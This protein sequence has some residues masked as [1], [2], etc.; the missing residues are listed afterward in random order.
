MKKINFIWTVMIFIALCAGGCSKVQNGYISDKLIYRRNPQIVSAGV[1]TTSIMPELNGTSQ[2]IH[3]FIAG[4]YDSIGKPTDLL[5]KDV[6]LVVWDQPYVLA[7]DTTIAL[8]N[9]KRKTIKMPI[10]QLNERSGQFTFTQASNLA[11]KG[12]YSF[13]VRMENVAGSQVFKNAMNID[14][15]Q[16]LYSPGRMDI[17]IMDVKNF[18]GGYITSPTATVKRIDRTPT[19]QSPNTISFKIVDKHG[20]PWNPKAGEIVPRGDRPSFPSFDRFAPQV[21]TDSTMTWAYPFAPFPLGT[22]ASTYNAYDVFYRVLMPR[23][24]IDGTV[25][26]TGAPCLPGK[27]NMNVTFGFR[28]IYF[29]DWE[30]TIHI[31]NATRI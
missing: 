31:D 23:V 25:P 24:A 20:K 15:Q 29:G 6:D 22:D 18:G 7:T 8:V 4:A 1:L 28:F 12:K 3:F 2:P 27:W 10:S 14:I 5:T 9:A 19:A 17:N 21:N 26:A 16:V 30:V 13:D 11:P